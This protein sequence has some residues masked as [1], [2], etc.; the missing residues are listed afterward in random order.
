M[1]FPALARV[2]KGSVTSASDRPPISLRFLS[3]DS[4]V[5]L[6]YLSFCPFMSAVSAF[7][8]M[9]V[10]RDRLCNID[11]KRTASRSS[12]RLSLLDV[13]PHNL[14]LHYLFREW[15]VALRAEDAQYWPWCWPCSHSVLGFAMRK[16]RPCT[17]PHSHSLER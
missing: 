4:H 10:L 13:M 9:L 8:T 6:H 1:G 17:N 3:S 12:E 11:W 15:S 2:N 16:R 7:A 5:E 14:T